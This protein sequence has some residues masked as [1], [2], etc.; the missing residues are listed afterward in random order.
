MFLFYC[1]TGLCYSN[2]AVPHAGNLHLLG[3]NG[4]G[5]RFAYVLP[6]LTAKVL[7]REYKAGAGPRFGLAAGTFLPFG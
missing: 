4:D 6:L 2:V 3:A 1:Y 5:H 7:L